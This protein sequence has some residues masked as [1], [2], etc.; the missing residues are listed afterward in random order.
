MPTRK[1]EI[2]LAVRLAKIDDGQAALIAKIDANHHSLTLQLAPLL[3]L[4]QT[5]KEHEHAISMWRGVNAAIGF[6]LT[7]IVALY[8]KL[9]LFHP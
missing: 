3:E 8:G 6:V 7:L 1:E 5:V 9:K 2:E 4:K